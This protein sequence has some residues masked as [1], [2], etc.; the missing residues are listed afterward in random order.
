MFSIRC[1]TCN[2]VLAHMWEEY[3]ASLREGE[4]P[5]PFFESK[6]VSRMCCR[7]MFLSHVDLTPELV[8]YPNRDVILDE[9]GMTLVKEVRRERTVSCD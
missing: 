7:R 6:K 9:T 5:I 8:L 3:S 2:A 1:Y 4:N